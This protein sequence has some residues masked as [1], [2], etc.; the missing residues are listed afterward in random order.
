MVMAAIGAVAVR[1]FQFE[2]PGL[3]MRGGGG[4][5]W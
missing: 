3:S 2:P 4:A 1:A 5:R